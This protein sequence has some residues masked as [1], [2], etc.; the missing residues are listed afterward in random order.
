MKLQKTDYDDMELFEDFRLFVR[1]FFDKSADEAAMCGFS[2]SRSFRSFGWQ[3]KPNLFSSKCRNSNQLQVNMKS[4]RA[5]KK[6]REEEI[7]VFYGVL[8]SVLICVVS[9]LISK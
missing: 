4:E 1:S 8:M 7:T 2:L 5:K 9:D 6:N 3:P